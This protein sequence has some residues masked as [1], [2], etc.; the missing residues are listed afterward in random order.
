MIQSLN[1]LLIYI[2]NIMR[3]I[4]YILEQISNNTLEVNKLT[5]VEKSVL[6]VLI[7]SKYIEKQDTD[8]FINKKGRLFLDNLKYNIE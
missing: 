3:N 8:F 5:D 6:K 1:Q 4:I 7:E 2:S